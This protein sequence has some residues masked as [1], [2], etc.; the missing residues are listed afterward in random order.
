[1]NI[2]NMLMG[3]S[4]YPHLNL[5]QLSYIDAGSFYISPTKKRNVG[6]RTTEIRDLKVTA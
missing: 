2:L 4:A 5:T 6:R 3:G 1:M